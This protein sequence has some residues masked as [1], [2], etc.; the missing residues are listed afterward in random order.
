MTF[1]RFLRMCSITPRFFE[2]ARYF[3]GAIV[4]GFARLNGYAIAVLASDPQVLGG[5]LDADAS[6]KMTRL[7]LG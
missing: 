1:V 4:T 5:S 6:E 3:G 2:M 7:E